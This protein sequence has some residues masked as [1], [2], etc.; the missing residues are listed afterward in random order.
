MIEL[1][2]LP[3][4]KHR[5]TPAGD[6]Y[7]CTSPYYVMFKGKGVTAEDCLFRCQHVNKGEPVK[8]DRRVFR[9][10]AAYLRWAAAG[11]PTRSAEEQETVQ[12]QCDAC[13]HYVKGLC[14]LCAC[15]IS[16]LI[17]NKKRMATEHCPIDKW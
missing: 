11:F 9:A 15:H 16:G 3:E 10:S 13:P 17:L 2:V 12:A 7:P 14:D 8:T 6:V 1:P 5:G 4:C